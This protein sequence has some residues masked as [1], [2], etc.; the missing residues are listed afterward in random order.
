MATLIFLSLIAFMIQPMRRDP[1]RVLDIGYG[2][3]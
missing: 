1:A 2:V 3:N